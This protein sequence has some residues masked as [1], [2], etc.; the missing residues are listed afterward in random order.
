MKQANESQDKK[1]T[2]IV[3]RLTSNFFLCDASITFF[4]VVYIPFFSFF[5]LY[6]PLLQSSPQYTLRE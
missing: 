4:R 2:F 1:A 3:M 6:F 5:F